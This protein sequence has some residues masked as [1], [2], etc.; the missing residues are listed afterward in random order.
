MSDSAEDVVR[1]Y[2]EVMNRLDM[3]DLATLWH[4][5]VV[6]RIPYAPDPIPKE[7][8][9]RE[10][11]QALW[12]GFPSLVT[13]LGFHDI[14]IEPLAEEGQF[15]VEY[16]SNCTMIPTGQPYRNHYIGRF[17]IR[18]GLIA[19]FAE[20]FDPLVFLAAQGATVAMPA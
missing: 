1:R 5:D 16:E 4:P 6:A 8:R 14:R 11:V 9:G 20:W 19:E 3:D 17:T 7:T 12:S 15:V 18:D 10:N 13:P 2:F